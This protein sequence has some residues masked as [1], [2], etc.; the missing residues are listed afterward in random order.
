MKDCLPVPLLLSWQRERDILGLALTEP[1]PGSKSN[2]SH[3]SLQL[4][5]STSKSLEP[6]KRVSPP[7]AGQQFIATVTEGQGQFDFVMSAPFI[8]SQV[9]HLEKIEHSDNP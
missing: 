2:P 9:T 7:A 8:V 1:R 6:N 3:L 5:A 4:L